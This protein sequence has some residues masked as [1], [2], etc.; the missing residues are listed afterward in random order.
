M[1]EQLQ[2]ERKLLPKGAVLLSLRGI[3]DAQT[4]EPL[5]REIQ[6]IFERGGF[7]LI[8]DASELQYVSSAG[9][10][11]LMNA[12]A[13][14][15]AHKGDLILIRITPEVHEIFDS[16]TLTN[17]FKFAPTQEEALELFA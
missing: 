3:L 8:I 5:E 16:L 2:F 15:T 12:M 6:S 4:F 10:G 1:P 7:K 17:V 14:C 9:L 13:E 11:V